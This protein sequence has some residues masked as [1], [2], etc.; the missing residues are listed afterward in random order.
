MKIL[1]VETGQHLYGGARQVQYLLAGLR[2]RGVDNV[3][4]APAGSA[5]AGVGEQLGVRVHPLTVGGG[6]GF[7]LF[8][9]LADL[10]ARERPALLHVHSRRYAVDFWGGLAARRR[11]LPAVLSRRVD[12]P[13]PGWL[14]RLKYQ[15]YAR[16]ITISEGIRR[17]LLDEGLAARQVMTVRSAVDV[18]EY[19]TDCDR[20]WMHETFALDSDAVVIGMIAQLIPRKGH[21]HLLRALVDVAPDYPRLRVLL[22]GKGALRD[23][24]EQQISELRLERTVALA[25]FRDDLNRVLPCLDLVVHPADM[26][27]LGVSLIQAAA[28]GVPLIASRAGGMPEIVRDGENGLLIPPG[29]VPA[30]ARALRTLLDDPGRRRALGRAGRALV[31]REFSVD[32][33]VEGNLAMYRDVLDAGRLS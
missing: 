33:M 17:V 6:T 24:I 23:E 26:E 5:I 10:L 25:G 19:T 18:G 29:D 3:L 31:E 16:V 11:G 13:E 8:R 1:H 22:F 7:R 20:A 12:N 4:A 15:P 2:A 27:G 21:R 14:A 28:C 30:L 9:E 32:A